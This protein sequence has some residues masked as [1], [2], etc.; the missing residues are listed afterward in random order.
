MRGS[1]WS[2][3]GIKA[4]SDEREI[5]RAYA[6]RLKTVHPEDDAVGFQEL[7]AAYDQAMRMARQ[8]HVSP[9]PSEDDHDTPP[10]D[11]N[12]SWPNDAVPRRDCE[13][14]TTRSWR[15]EERSTAPTVGLE[16]DAATL[17]DP[18][19]LAE[20]AHR[21][22]LENLHRTLQQPA[23]GADEVVSALLGILRS[24]E[25]SNLSRHERTEA[26][27]ADVILR[28]SPG[29]AALVE[30]VIHY[31]GWT[32][33]RIVVGRTT[34]FPS[35]GQRVLAH[36]D[37][38]REIDLIL[39]GGAE[40]ADALK[41]LAHPVIWRTWAAA[42][43]TPGLDGRVAAFLNGPRWRLPELQ[44]NLDS[45]AVDWWTRR[46]DRPH[47]SPI[48]VWII[49]LGPP[50]I[51]LFAVNAGPLDTSWLFGFPRTWA[52]S[53]VS[54]AAPLLGW[55]FILSEAR[56]RWRRGPAWQAPPWMRLGW[57]PGLLALLAG[58][59]LLPD[60]SWSLLVW[61]PVPVLVLWALV[62]GEAN[63]DPE[64]VEKSWAMWTYVSLLT[65]GLYLTQVVWRP[66][67]RYPWRVRAIFA[68]FWLVAFWLVAMG[69][70]GAAAGGL[71]EDAW[72]RLTVPLLGAVIAFS[73]SAG[74]LIDLWAELSTWTR[75]VTAGAIATVAIIGFALLWQGAALRPLGVALL[76]TA[77]L[78]HKAPAFD[79]PPT[80]YVVRDLFMRFGWFLW[81]IVLAIVAGGPGKA[82]AIH[83]A[84]LCLMVG[85]L[86]GV[87]ARWPANEPPRQRYDLAD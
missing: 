19:A 77:V 12:P 80:G 21:A 10:V 71:S 11:I 43:L 60:A 55:R 58:A 15:E 82:G 56:W 74:T 30:P 73:A 34:T 37:R 86:M 49:L 16:P 63:R 52:V 81:P 1:I 36:L 13:V 69:A 27:L 41:A 46:L 39:N 14:S 84:G 85:V 3:L 59:A 54:V 33:D 75:R 18:E 25:M 42:L 65:I 22:R 32:D 6:R 28:G 70:G 8:G 44:S 51:A 78:A 4:T 62:V 53:L 35:P 24:E 23:P 38:R 17:P 57:A 31:F 26:W 76:A 2:V 9:D 87:L 5:R 61:I 7:R 47:F 67:M 83:G 68:H 66:G 48:A 29:T 20:R 64:P 72:L 79:L 40:H 45:S 50:L